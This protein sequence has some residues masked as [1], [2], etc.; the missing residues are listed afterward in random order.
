MILPSVGSTS[1]SK[2]GGVNGFSQGLTVDA[3]IQAVHQ[4][5]EFL[6][7]KAT[8]NDPDWDW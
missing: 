2:S 7:N 6:Q 1:I 3:V 8:G 4:G 5:V